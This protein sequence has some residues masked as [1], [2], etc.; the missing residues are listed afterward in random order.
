[1]RIAKAPLIALAALA[2]LAAPALAKNAK[3][4][5]I[6]TEEASPSCYSYQL[7]P[8]GNWAQLPCQETGTNSST[9]HRAPPKPHE[10]EA[11]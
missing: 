5:K 7:G 1:M 11:H 10:E 9:Q 2:V 8:D 3:V 4:Q 6:E